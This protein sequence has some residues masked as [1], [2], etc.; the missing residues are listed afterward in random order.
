LAK[1]KFTKTLFTEDTQ[2]QGCIDVLHENG[3]AVFKVDDLEK[4]AEEEAVRKLRAVGYK[5]EHVLD[6]VVK[7]DVGRITT[8]DDVALYFH[9]KMK[10]L[11]PKR[12]TETKLKSKRSRLVDHSVI[13]SFISW[14]LSEGSSLADALSDMF[15]VID[16]LFDT[17]VEKKIDIRGLGILSVNNNKPFVMSLMYEVRNRKDAQL[18]FDTEKLIFKMDED[19]RLEVLKESKE[20]LNTIDMTKT[21]VKRRLIGGTIG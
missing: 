9:T 7:V 11:N 12:H 3:Y 13:N 4:V 1:K 5:V 10:R 19:S 16:I 14:R 17:F 20:K 2:V 6:S 18:N 21:I 15:V 8:V